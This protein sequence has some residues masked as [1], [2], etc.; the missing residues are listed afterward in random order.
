MAYHHQN[1]DLKENNVSWF[2]FPLFFIIIKPM[3]LLIVG[4]AKTY[5]YVLCFFLLPFITYIYRFEFVQI[6]YLRD[7]DSS[8]D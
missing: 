2:N 8:K 1:E 6:T 3:W 7:E 4:C 5:K